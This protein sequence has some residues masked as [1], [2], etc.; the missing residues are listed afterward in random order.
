MDS[1]KANT[2]T[3]FEKPIY[4]FIAYGVCFVSLGL[5]TA[6]LGPMLPFLADKA[7]VSLA[8]ISFLFT[9]D[10]LGYMLGA[11]GGGRLY[12]RFDS[13]KLMILALVM[14]VVMCILIPLTPV[15]AV[16]LFMMFLFGFSR[17]L[18]D[19]G[20]NVNLV[21]VYRSRVGPY[22]NGLHFCFGVG[23]FFGP[24]L[25]HFV[26]S[27]F[28]EVIT[29]PYWTLA[30]L[31]LF[32]L[33]GLW[34]LKS[35]VD[36][37]IEKTDQ[38]KQPLNVQLIVLMILLFF[39]YVSVEGGFSG[40][41]FTYA[42]ETGIADDAGASLMTSI[43]WGSLTIGRL[44]SMLVAKRI[45]PSRLLISNFVLAILVLGLA[46]GWPTNPIIMWTV[47]AGLGMALSSVFPTLLAL[48]ESRM[49]ITG[50]VTGLFFLGSS[51][52]S[53]LSPMI[54][55]QIFEYI[56]SYQI[57][58]TLFGLAC[59]GLVILIFV[60]LASNRVAEKPRNI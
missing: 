60:I 36:P 35:P 32:G 53:T 4:Y 7:L 20:C 59:A 42:T 46:V 47:S 30:V 15:Y 31:F 52:G 27:L 44:I 28:G 57:M 6:S 21:W 19:V 22:L 39:A 41:I 23:A 24:I 58:L 12:D 51:L 55:G 45:R 2:K 25:I 26:M 13:H 8:K 40:W 16:W 5:G 11:V 54:L 38:N 56:G 3:P 10:S 29:W 14:M 1:T 34:R 37:D 50:R 49:K 18:L 48:G 43:F 17:G 9:T 33:I